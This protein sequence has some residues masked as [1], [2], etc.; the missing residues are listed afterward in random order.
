MYEENKLDTQ[1]IMNKTLYLEGFSLDGF[2]G[3]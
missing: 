3:L 2:I 1:F